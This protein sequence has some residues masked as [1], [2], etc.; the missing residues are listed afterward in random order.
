MRAGQPVESASAPAQVAT[1]GWLFSRRADL[2]VI[3]LPFA[4]ALVMFSLERARGGGRTIERDYA[5]FLS[6]F[7]LGNTTHVILT[8]LAFGVRRDLLSPVPG[9]KGILV[10]GSTA[11]F[12]AS[13]ALFWATSVAFPAWVDFGITIGFVF[14]QHHRLSQIKGV[15]AL[16]SLRAKQPP[17]PGERRIQNNFVAVGLLMLVSR[18]LLFPR[19]PG[20]SSAQ[21][22]PIPGVA[23]PLPFTGVYVL[24]AVFAV[25]GVHALRQVSRAGASV[26]KRLYL[27]AHV[28]ALALTLYEPIWGLVVTSG[29]HGLEYYFLTA[30]M[31]ETRDGDT[32]RISR[33][34]AWGLMALSMAPLLVVGSLAA[35][36]AGH[37]AQLASVRIALVALNSIVMAHY[38]ADAFLYRL[39]L[40]EVRKVVLRRLGF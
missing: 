40:P 33:P 11:A 18:L 10:F 31:L 39:R 22:S 3:A 5:V 13:F 7:L 32:R 16:Y 24:L 27:T 1:S 9:Q 14:A 19:S 30:Q 8:F 28:A 15:W 34:L 26:P 6:Q 37:V 2:A 20:V 17:S 25:F 23:A 21:L 38:F 36:F 35:P 4:L 29:I 12:V